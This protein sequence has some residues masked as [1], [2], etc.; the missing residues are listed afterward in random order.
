MNPTC[1]G[2]VSSLLMPHRIF[3]KR[4]YSTDR[5]G[6]LQSYLTSA[7]LSIGCKADDWFPSCK[8]PLVNV[9]WPEDSLKEAG[10]R[11]SGTKPKTRRIHILEPGMTKF[12]IADSRAQ[13]HT[14]NT[15][16]ISRKRTGTTG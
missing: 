6:C 4:T 16:L 8:T 2:A 5:I 15:V 3:S 10:A 14:V 11:M 7:K 12:P 13:S 1:N 9:L